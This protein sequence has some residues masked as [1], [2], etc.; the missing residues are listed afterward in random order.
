MRLLAFPGQVLYTV[1]GEEPGVG[2][3]HLPRQPSA[4]VKI[5]VKGGTFSAV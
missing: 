5:V 2:N 3:T 1:T 4:Y